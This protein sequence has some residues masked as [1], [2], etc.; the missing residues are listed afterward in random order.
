LKRTC[1]ECAFVLLSE[2]FGHGFGRYLFV[3]TACLEL[4]DHAQASAS[5]DVDGRPRV[6][7]R[8]APVVEAAGLNQT[9]DGCVDLV[10]RVLAGEQAVATLG[11]RE[12]PS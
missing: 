3:D 8:E 4:S 9:G 6:R 7:L 12:R 10:F 5:L 1:D 11:G 2:D